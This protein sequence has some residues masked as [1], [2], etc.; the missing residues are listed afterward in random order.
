MASAHLV[1]I[2]ALS[3]GWPYGFLV[4]MDQA[5]MKVSFTFYPADVQALNRCM[6]DLRRAGLPVRGGTVLRALIHLTSS[7]EL[8]AHAVLLAKAYDRKDGPREADYVAGHPTVDLP[9]DLV[10]KLD[11]VVTE[12]ADKMIPANRAFIVRALLRAAPDAATLAPAVRKYL[13]AFPPRP[14]GWAAL[15]A[16]KRGKP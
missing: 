3:R 16:R 6:G 14:R 8:F 12:L 1:G 11:D 9:P 5:P 7:T 10:K 15:K 13:A 2:A 4:M